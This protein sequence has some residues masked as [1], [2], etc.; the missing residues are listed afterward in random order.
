MAKDQIHT[1]V[2]GSSHGELGFAAPEC[3][4]LTYNLAFE[5]QDLWYDCQMVRAMLEKLPKLKRVVFCMSVFSFRY[6]ICDTDSERWREAMY[7]HACGLRSRVDDGDERRYSPLSLANSWRKVEQLSAKWSFA[8][9]PLLGWRPQAGGELDFN[10]GKLAAERHQN[11]GDRRVRENQALLSATIKMCQQKGIE[12]VLISIPTFAGYRENLSAAYVA[13]TRALL[14]E[15]SAQTGTVYL[16]YSEDAR[17]A[18]GDF[19]DVDH[20]NQAGAR[21]FVRVFE[22]DAS[23]RLA[24]HEGFDRTQRR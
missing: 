24:E 5:S 19:Y 11:H 7:Y 21:R 15:I 2:V 1:I 8:K 6:S 13:E 23:L 10:S 17:F 20:L 14:H 16:D 22:E 12:C 4:D 9:D 18:E 3:R